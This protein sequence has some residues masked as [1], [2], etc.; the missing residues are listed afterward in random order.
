MYGNCSCKPNVIGSKCD[1]CKADYYDVSQSC[2]GMANTLS[3][4][5][6][7]SNLDLLLPWRQPLWVGW[8]GSVF[9]VL[10]GKLFSLC[11]DQPISTAK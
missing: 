7:I 3:A 11:L 5:P 4:I 2:L 6:V 8:V 1:T 10:W 9:C